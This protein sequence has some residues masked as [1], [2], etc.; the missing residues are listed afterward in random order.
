MRQCSGKSARTLTVAGCEVQTLGI[1]ETI[2]HLASHA[3]IDG[4]L[5]FK[6]LHLA[7]VA[8]SLE[9]W[10]P[11]VN[12]DRLW[13]TVERLGVRA[14]FSM[15]LLALRVLLRFDGPFALADRT[16]P[17]QR[18]CF[19]LATNEWSIVHLLRSASDVQLSEELRREAFWDLARHRWPTPNLRQAVESV[20]LRR[21]RR[22]RHAVSRARSRG[23][24]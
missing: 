1:D 14:D 3:L 8:W 17:W 10:G 9:R 12:A 20:A 7:D 15:A 2:A 19:R 22:H 24:A 5:L 11:N 21:H 4:P 6:L 16:S 23:R 13:R 18:L